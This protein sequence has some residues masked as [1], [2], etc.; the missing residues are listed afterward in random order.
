MTLPQATGTKLLIGR[1]N[2]VDG[3]VN[4]IRSPGTGGVFLI[5]D[6]G[7]GKSVTSRMV[8]K[9]LQRDMSVV[10]VHATSSLAKVPFGVLAAFLTDLPIDEANSPASILR[11]LWTNL[12]QSHR[13]RSHPLLLVVDDADHLDEGSARVIAELV[14]AGWA[15]VLITARHQPGP[16]HDLARLW[17]EGISERFELPPLNRDQVNQMCQGA[18]GGPVA[19]SSSDILWRASQGNPMLVQVLLDESCESES[20]V[21]QHGVWLFAGS[22]PRGAALRDTMRRR[23]LRLSEAEREALQLVALAEPVAH[24][25][26]VAISGAAAVA[27]LVEHQLIRITDDDERVL[28]L[29]TPLYGE[30]IRIMVS[31]PR[32]LVLRA[33][34]QTELT[35]EPATAEGALRRV[36]WALDCGLAVPDRLLIR[37]A[38]LASQRFDNDL[39]RRAAAQIAG[40]EHQPRAQVIIARAHYNCGE[41]TAAAALLEPVFA[42]GSDVENLCIG[43]L[44]W[45]STRLALA[46]PASALLTDADRVR[47]AGKRAAVA[48]PE[49]STQILQETEDASALLELMALSAQGNF[50]A[51]GDKLLALE[52]APAAQLRT[53]ETEVFILVTR[54]EWLCARGL[55]LQAR[56]QLEQAIG[57]SHGESEQVFFFAEFIGLRLVLSLLEAGDWKGVD[58]ALERFVADSGVGLIPFGGGFYV[59]RCFLLLR[60]QRHAQ[61]LASVLAGVEPLR[62]NDPQ[63]LFQL[64][65][66]MAFYAAAALGQLDSAPELLA[67]FESAQQGGPMLTRWYADAFVA[68]GKEH[69]S[70]DGTGLAELHGL[71]DRLSTE[72]TKAVELQAL[73]LCLSLNDRSRLSRF[74]AVAAGCEGPWAAAL[75]AYG[76]ALDDGGAADFIRA[77]ETLRAVGMTPLAAECF[78]TAVQMSRRD[79][80]APKTAWAQTGLDAC[81]AELGYSE[82][83]TPNAADVEKIL[84]PRERTITSLALEGLTDR[85]IAERLHS[86]VRTVEGHLY[87]SYAKLGI[88]GRSELGFVPRLHS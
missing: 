73:F 84:T 70:K 51:L 17:Y 18:L 55:P 11:T 71:A 3:A 57:L 22:L 74:R 36:S 28:R 75:L 81:I 23:F 78:G 43:S 8:A 67:D 72:A 40:S 7:F 82:G 5:G 38:T 49:K 62:N 4:A 83:W 69:C 15:K 46:H 34:L 13:L 85:Q 9:I 12:E 39:A 80:D 24:E 27:A 16:P 10:S 58:A 54:A 20:L 45:G 35:E 25:A 87:R 60:Q 65:T 76:Q 53:P 52:Q 59:A 29:W 31:V 88:G 61:A 79:G 77:A 30:A 64:A 1:E 41:Y 48:H 44:L 47:L 56:I 68:A 6:S 19:A 63:Q 26:V 2:I 32:S 37:T 42:T 33:Q 66:A 50:S 86:S 21:L 14:S